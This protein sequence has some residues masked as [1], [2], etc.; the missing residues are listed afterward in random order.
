MIGSNYMK[1]TIAIV[2][3]AMTLMAAGNERTFT[4]V[5]TDSMCGKDHAMMKMPPDEKCV[6]ECV[7][8]SPSVKF[9][10]YDGSKVYKLSDQAAPEKFAG[11]KVTVTGVL[12]PETGIISVKSIQAA[13]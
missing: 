13:K 11:K 7:K 8:S 3:C 2:F 12:Y 1:K 10:L 6:R 4:G 9:A 5:I